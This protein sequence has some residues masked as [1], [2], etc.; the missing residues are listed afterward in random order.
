MMRRFLKGLPIRVLWP[1]LVAIAVVGLAV[2]L[3]RPHLRGHDFGI[4]GS[5]PSFMTAAF[6]CFVFA[7]VRPPAWGYQIGI[8]V[9]LI[10]VELDQAINNDTRRTFDYWDMIASV[11]GILISHYVLAWIAARHGRRGSA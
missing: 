8:A 7:V 10:G 1:W 2:K 3:G 11:A 9:G 4:T 6:F 5:A